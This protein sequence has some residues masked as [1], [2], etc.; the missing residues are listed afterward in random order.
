MSSQ[1]VDDTR[2]RRIQRARKRGM[3][4]GEIAAREGVSTRTI[5]RILS[6]RR[7][8]QTLI[9]LRPQ[10]AV[11]RLM[12]TN[13]LEQIIEKELRVLKTAQSTAGPTKGIGLSIRDLIDLECL[14]ALLQ[15]QAEALL[16]EE[17]TEQTEPHSH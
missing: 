12:R 4:V 13:R 14:S 5:E 16:A 1:T 7:F 8:Q 9:E 10:M 11:R 17:L 2:R 3:T 15:Q 6:G